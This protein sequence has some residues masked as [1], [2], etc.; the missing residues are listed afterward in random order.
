ML[1]FVSK[2]LITGEYLHI[3]KCCAKLREKAL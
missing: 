3:V 1:Y 2:M